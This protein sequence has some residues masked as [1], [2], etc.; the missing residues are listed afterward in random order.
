MQPD[1][2]EQIRHQRIHVDK[3]TMQRLEFM[4]SAPSRE[5][6]A[7]QN[8]ER[9]ANAQAKRDRN[10][11]KSAPSKNDRLHLSAAAVAFARRI[12]HDETR[13]RRE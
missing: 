10:K 11:R 13:I 2:T 12:L 5:I 6:R 3:D 9:I 7:P 4:K 1:A 8:I